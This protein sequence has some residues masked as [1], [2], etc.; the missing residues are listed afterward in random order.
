MYGRESQHVEQEFADQ[1]ELIPHRSFAGNRPSNTLLIDKITPHN[2][3]AL[4]ALYE[5]KIFVQGVIWG[6]NSFDQWGVELGKQLA[7]VVLPELTG[8]D[9]EHDGSTHQLIEYYRRHKDSE[10]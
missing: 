10:G 4:I 2:L 6:I 9:G 1:P 8:A 7:K 5:H 3:G